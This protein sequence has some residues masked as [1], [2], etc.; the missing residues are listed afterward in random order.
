M[1]NI[2]YLNA[3][4]YHKQ[5][6]NISNVHKTLYNSFAIKHFSSIHVDQNDD[7][8]FKSIKDWWDVNGT[9]QTLHAYNDVR[10]K[11]LK[12]QLNKELSTSSHDNTNTSLQ[13]SEPF[14]TLHML[15][16]GCGGGI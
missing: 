4:K 15:D 16:V 14:K 13:K 5:I 7:R 12:K 2:K 11:Y 10:I 3:F 6:F 8:F 1:K 9:M